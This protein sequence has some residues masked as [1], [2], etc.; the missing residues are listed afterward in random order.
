M[1]KTWKPILSLLL[2][3]CITVSTA[4]GAIAIGR[5]SAADGAANWLLKNVAVDPADQEP[6]NIVDWAAFALARGGYQIDGDY[7][8]YIDG[9]VRAN[10][11]QLYLSDY[12]RIALAVA[13]AGGDARN[14]GGHDLIEAIAQTDFTREIYTDGVSFALLAMDSMRYELPETVRKAAVDALCSAPTGRMAAL[15]MRFVSIR[16]TPIRLMEA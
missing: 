13:A 5:A 11:S 1:K 8:Q 2:A 7:L 3:L 16:R 10:F 15:I 12:A 6:D 14:V 9:V 4:A